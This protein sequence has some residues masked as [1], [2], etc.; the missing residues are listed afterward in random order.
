MYAGPDQVIS[1]S[2][3]I[4]VLLGFLVSSWSRLF[5]YAKK[6]FSKKKHDEVEKTYSSLGTKSSDQ[7][8]LDSSPK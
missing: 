6:I 8:S 2:S 1:F 7:G 5:T 4:A 3:F